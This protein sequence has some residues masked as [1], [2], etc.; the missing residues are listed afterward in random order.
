MA[1]LKVEKKTI[2]QLFADAG[3]NTCFLIPD[4]QRPYAW[5][6]TECS[7]LWNDIYSFAFP[8]NDYT[9][10]NSD[11]LYFLGPI[12][13]FK[14]NG[15]LEVIDGQQRI[16]TLMLLLRALYEAYGTTSRDENS[17]NTK[18][19]ISQCLWKTDEFDNPDT[20]KLRIESEVA[21][22]LLK[23]EFT[24]ILLTGEAPDEFKSNYAENYRFFQDKITQLLQEA[25]VHFPY[26]TARIL[27]NCILFP[28]EADS[29]DDALRIFSTL[30]DRGKPLSDSDIFKAQLYKAF[31]DDSETQKEEF[32]SKWKDL[33]S[34]CYKIFK[35]GTDNPMD[36]LFT[37]YMYYERAKRGVKV[38]TLEGLRKFYETDN[39]KLLRE[40]HSQTFNNLILLAEFWNDISK[41]NPERFADRVLRRLFVLNYAPNSMWTYITSVYFLH[42]KDINNKLDDEKFYN[43]LNTITAFI[44]A[45]T[46]IRPGVNQ[47]R[48]PVFNEMVNIV[49]N[50]EVTFQDFKFNTEELEQILSIYTFNHNRPVTR[51]MLTWY[52][53]NDPKQELIPIETILEI[54][55]IYAKN[56]QPVPA[57]LEAIGNKSLLE[58]KINIRASDY[59]FVD[60]RKYYKGEVPRRPRTQIHELIELAE[61]DDF[62]ESDI[63]ARNNKIIQSFIN[64]IINNNLAK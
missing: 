12:V 32:I 40:N 55:H 21:T 60:K 14:N 50:K 64:F 54:E 6:E 39:Y 59:R 46:I 2:K 61:Q 4:Y 48:T 24:K 25:P 31:T 13:T 29:M 27:K 3:R 7:T 36:E 34:T 22:E 10:F 17:I 58:K 42:N 1:E 52:A 56:R 35:S 47:L 41:Q 26:M 16:I 28:I 43:F 30:N 20:S 23:E 63:Q 45:F 19:T 9:K 62:T 15:K 49:N 18:R 38:S 5:E 37:R 8:D 44:W 11:N 33:E 53:F 57:N 51:S